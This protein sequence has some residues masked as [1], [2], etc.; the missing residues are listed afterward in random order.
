MRNKLYISYV[1][2]FAECAYCATIS[3]LFSFPKCQNL[4][5][6]TDVVVSAVYG[7]ANDILIATAEF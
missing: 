4:Q 7:A 5:N 3:S 1:R 2:L 6:F